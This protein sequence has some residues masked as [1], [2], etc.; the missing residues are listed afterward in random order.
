MS[1]AD[2]TNLDNYI[3]GN[4]QLP[5][6]RN[7]IEEFGQEAFKRKAKKASNIRAAIARSQWQ[8]YKKRFQPLEN[9][10]LGYANNR[11]GYIADA[12]KGALDR[13]NQ[14]YSGGEAQIQRRM[15]SFGLQITPEM[16]QR[17]SK[18]L[19]YQKGLAQVQASNMA[20]REAEGQLDTIVGGGLSMA[21]QA[22]RG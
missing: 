13:V 17:I 9:I 22:T 2:L 19:G 1:G 4:T 11:Q 21:S 16:Q 18:R 6:A 15:Q 5:D 20:R 10:L 12:Q 14:A 7:E 8:D 3:L